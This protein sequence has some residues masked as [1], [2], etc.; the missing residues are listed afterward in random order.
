LVQLYSRLPK[1]AEEAVECLSDIWALG[2]VPLHKDLLEA[3]VFFA[4]PAD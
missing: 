4:Q 3:A 2:P 1:E